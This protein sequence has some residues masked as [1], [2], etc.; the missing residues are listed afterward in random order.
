[1]STLAITAAYFVTIPVRYA[2]GRW[3]NIPTNTLFA[4]NA[5]DLG[6][7]ILARSIWRYYKANEWKLTFSQNNTMLIVGRTCIALSALYLTSKLTDPMPIECAVMTTLASVTFFATVIIFA[8][9]QG[10][11]E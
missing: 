3:C 9:S 4:F 6:L 1:M 8:A 2:V 7:T 5:A 11:N 10:K